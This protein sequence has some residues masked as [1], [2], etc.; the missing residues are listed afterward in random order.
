MGGLVRTVGL[1]PFVWTPSNQLK[2]IME[3]IMAGKTRLSAC[4]PGGMAVEFFNF[5]VHTSTQ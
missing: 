5:K 2:I 4:P 3:Q 1:I